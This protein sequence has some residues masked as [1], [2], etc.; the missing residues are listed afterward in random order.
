MMARLPQ[1]DPETLSGSRPTTPF[2]MSP[3][4]DWDTLNPLNGSKH[5]AFEELCAQLARGV[6]PPDSKFE[7]K[8]TP[9]AGVEA[10]AV[11]KDSSEWA[12]QAK[13]FRSLGESQW[14]QLDASVEAA[15]D[16]HPRLQR[17]FICA[18]MDLPDGRLGRAKSARQRWN[19]RVATWT[20]AARRKGMSVEFV[21]QGSHELFT[22][23]ARPEHA[24][25]AHYFLGHRFLD[26]DW[27]TRRFHEARQAAGPRYTPD[28]NIQLELGEQFE[29]FGRV[30]SFFDRI[31]S[32]AGDIREHAHG[33]TLDATKAPEASLKPLLVAA[34][35]ECSQVLIDLQSLSDDPSIS[36]P[37]TPLLASLHSARSST[38]EALTEISRLWK[39][40]KPALPETPGRPSSRPHEDPR[41]YPVRQLLEKLREAMRV[42]RAFEKIAKVRL[43]ILSGE[44]GTGKTHLLCDLARQRL[45]AGLPTVLVMGHRLL[46]L[47]DPWIQV[48]QQ[49]D[50]HN[51]TAQDFVAALEVVAR[52]A[53]KRLLFMVDAINEGA[54]MRLWP[55]HLSPFLERLAASP[56][57]AVVL[58]VRSSYAQDVIPSTGL[59][60]AIHVEHHGFE[61]VEFEATRS[62]FEHYGINL[63]STPLLAPEFRNPLYLK[64]LCKGLQDAGEC[65]LPRGFH[66]V[67]RGFELYIAG[68]ND[69]LAR[70]LDFPAKKNLVAK[71]LHDMAQLMV[72]DR[73]AWLS[74]SQAESISDRLLPGR[75]HSRALLPRLIA[76]GLLIEER[77]W[78]RHHADTESVVMMAY[79]RLSDYQCVQVLMEGVPKSAA[80]EDLF[81]EEG[82]LGFKALSTTWSRPGFHEAL[83]TLVAEQTGRE[84]LDLAPDLDRHHYTAKAF[85]NSIVWRDPA[86]VTSRTERLLMSFRT[87]RSDELIDTLITVATVPGHPLNARFL[88]RE[89]RKT[90]MADRDA[91]WSTGLHALWGEQSAVDRLVLWSGR[92][93]PQSELD[94]E[95]AELVATT[96]AWLLASSHRSLRDHATKSLVRVMTWRPELISRMVERF[97]GLDDA[98]VS[99]RVVAAA[100]GAVMR[101]TDTD[102]AKLVAEAAYRAV[103]ASGKPRPHI[104]LR[105]YARGIVKRAMHLMGPAGVGVWPGVDPPYVSDWPVIPEQSAIDALLP[106]WSANR[107][108]SRILGLDRIRNSVMHD[109]FGRYIIG[110]NSGSSNWLSVPLSEPFWQSLERRVAHAV[111]E[112]GAEPREAW[113]DFEA[114]QRSASL[115][116]FTKRFSHSDLSN[117]Q[118]A[119]S[120]ADAPS[121]MDKRVLRARDR[122]LG[123][124]DEDQRNR[125]LNLMDEL[126]DS[127][128]MRLAPYFN[129]KLVQRYV[130]HRVLDLGWTPERFDQFDRHVQSDGRRADKAE[131]IGKKYQWIAYHEMLAYLADHYQYLPNTS[132]RDVATVYRGSWQD[133]FRDID[134][135]NVMPSIS[136][137]ST[138]PGAAAVF[139]VP[140]TIAN[141]FARESARA[142]AMQTHDVPMPADLLFCTDEPSRS[143][144]VNFHV[145][146]NWTKQRPADEALHTDSQRTIWM[147]AEAVL[148]RRSEVSNLRKRE[149]TSKIIQD[150]VHDNGNYTIYLGEVGWSEAA[151]DFMNPYHGNLGWAGDLQQ[152]GVNAIPASSGYLR[153]SSTHDCSIGSR[154]IKL[155]VPSPQLLDLLDADWSGIGA[156]YVDRA[157]TGTVLAFDPSANCSGPSAF[158]V[159]KESLLELMRCHDLVVCWRVYGE[160]LDAAGA[161]SYEFSARRTFAGLFSWDGTEVRGRY[162]FGAVEVPQ[163]RH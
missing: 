82:K 21:W 143:D 57:I 147:Y 116:R 115:Y 52:R 100:Y 17:Y 153:E 78:R 1:I 75:D 120:T 132:A 6:C 79:E 72:S 84:L 47:S 16:G 10:Y 65:R 9:D 31:R 160:K 163:D 145:D 140:T 108:G 128:G 64:T 149:G 123:M 146:L 162:F 66:G 70:E 99:E 46:E 50:L 96:L 98:Y 26:D 14:K 109:D 67:V 83:H 157:G 148:V 155:R 29:A 18:P 8:G 61:N 3:D 154:T 42:V 73:C 125:F 161:P 28:L 114:V 122:L 129:L 68:A 86:T 20:E 137:L 2:L 33:L 126:L 44:A 124:L 106:P 110:T 49:L 23:L 71:A 51:W 77:R 112:L 85:L 11:L 119:G 121:E 4:F 53:G 48:L 74:Y 97:S 63:P 76:E 95:E 38:A 27:F 62:F 133:R 58:S 81:R 103:F 13:Y 134:P 24:G 144:W 34:R 35:A 7:R 127:Q 40:P 130:A 88:D 43:L 12:W 36:S 25:L 131:R 19:E 59:P 156:T 55:V 22:L 159:R 135:S 39:D 89:L 90:G 136:D 94:S 80:W 69:R 139:W 113:K 91:W 107:S 151:G 15:L 37:L 104:L 152:R 32:V 5:A 93:W 45:Q 102:G 56:W 105:E 142:W 111:E 41:A 117:D 60:A 87:T 150:G 138:P 54:G 118:D 158:L 92:L 101:T 141:W 30:P